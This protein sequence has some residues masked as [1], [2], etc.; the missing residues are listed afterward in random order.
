MAFFY[1]DK[2]ASARS[3]PSHPCTSQASR[4]RKH[5]LKYR[6]S[7][8]MSRVR[9]QTIVIK[10]V[11]LDWNSHP[12]HSGSQAPAQAE[13]TPPTSWGLQLADGR[14]RDFSAPLTI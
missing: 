5:F 7:S 11:A 2:D 1:A 10:R 3:T 4:C 9:F 12:R 6:Q 8:E 13:K 14:S